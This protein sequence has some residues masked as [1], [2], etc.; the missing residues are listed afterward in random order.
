MPQDYENQAVKGTKMGNPT[1]YVGHDEARPLERLF[2]LIDAALG[3]DALGA[4]INC[5]DWLGRLDGVKSVTTSGT[6]EVTVQMETDALPD[7]VEQ[8][9]LAALVQ[10]LGRLGQD[11]K[12]VDLDHVE[13]R[14]EAT[15]RE[16]RSVW[17]ES[18]PAAF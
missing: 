18:G 2:S 17:P 4:E 13:T 7:K 11:V 14:P 1:I 12:V 16:T 15:Y 6:R 8:D 3:A 9:V 10:N 5:A